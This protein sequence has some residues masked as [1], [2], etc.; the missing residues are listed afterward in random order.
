MWVVGVVMGVRVRLDSSMSTGLPSVIASGV[1]QGDSVDVR[2]SFSSMYLRKG[3]NGRCGGGWN[4][5]GERRRCCVCVRPEF[6]GMK[7]GCRAE[8]DIGPWMMRWS[9]KPW[10]RLAATLTMDVKTVARA[11][12]NPDGWR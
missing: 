10:G 7:R 12:R 5:E 9:A 4:G 8:W 3:G 11:L 6:G 1:C 2:T